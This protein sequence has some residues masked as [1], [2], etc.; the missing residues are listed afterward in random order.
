MDSQ[1]SE[2]TVN[3]KGQPSGALTNA[4]SDVWNAHGMNIKF[5]YLL[6]DI[7]K[8]LNE[9]KYEQIPQ[10]SCGNTLDINGTFGLN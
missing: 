9:R 5:K 1:I 2:D 8:I 4:L 6:W 7:R 3:E 10:I